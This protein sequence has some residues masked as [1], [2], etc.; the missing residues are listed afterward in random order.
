MI[1]VG[2]VFFRALFFI[3][4]QKLVEADHF[5]PQ[6]MFWHQR[7][8]QQH[9]QV[10]VS[11]HWVQADQLPGCVANWVENFSSAWHVNELHTLAISTRCSDTHGT[12]D[13]VVDIRDNGYTR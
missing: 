8:H 2:F 3:Q 13:G 1:R 9:S 12:V 6:S 7:F 5:Q 10:L 4:N 11:L